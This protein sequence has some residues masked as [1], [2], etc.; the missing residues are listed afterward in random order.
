MD[1]KI[2]EIKRFLSP[3][4]VSND[5]PERTTDHEKPRTYIR[6]KMQAMERR[7]LEEGLFNARVLPFKKRHIKRH[8]AVKRAEVNI[9]G[10]IRP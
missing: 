10:L 6:K 7:F 9:Y 8:S 1:N 5:I 4:I 2:I 3:V